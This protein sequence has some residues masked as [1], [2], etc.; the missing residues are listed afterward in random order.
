MKFQDYYQTLGVARNASQAEIKKAYRKLAQKYHPDRNPGA[1]AEAKFKEINEAY[2]V[3]GDT[4]KR[5]RYDAL[6]QGYHA[7]DDF[8]GGGFG[9]F[10]GAQRG[11]DFGQDYRGFSDFFSQFF[12]G[13]FQPGGAGSGRAYQQHR[14]TPPPADIEV[15]AIVPIQTL[16][17][18]GQQTLRVPDER[19]QTRTLK[20]TIPAGFK[21]GK[22]M[23]LSGQG[24]KGPGGTSDLLVRM[25]LSDDDK[26]RVVGDTVYWDL[27]VT[28]WEAALGGKVPTTLP[29]GTRINMSIPANSQSGRKMRVPK[30]GFN[31]GDLMLVLQIHTPPAN[32]PE[33]R[34]FYEEMRASLPFDPRDKQA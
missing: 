9:G 18:G 7:G 30:R 13:G 26:R 24:R 11:A 14:S 28:P 29:D 32:T 27:P 1:D 21:P 34:E 22:K 4:E 17:A 10:G 5:A 31:G 25:E 6:S 8:R 15:Q 23:R 2:E 16:L 19:G 12:G 20:V 3:I 33:A